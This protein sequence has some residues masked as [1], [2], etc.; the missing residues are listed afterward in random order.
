M[1]VMMET[2]LISTISEIQLCIRFDI[3]RK[4][5]IISLPEEQRVQIV[6]LDTPGSS[7]ERIA[8]DSGLK[9]QLFVTYRR[10]LPF[11]LGNNGASS[12]TSAS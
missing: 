7:W 4:V 6:S 10:P 1:P 11:S 12:A 8:K 2:G 9:I 3:T 5:Q